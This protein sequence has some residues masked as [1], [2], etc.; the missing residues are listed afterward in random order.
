MLKQLKQADIDAVIAACVAEQA[1][2]AAGA[3]AGP[4]PGQHRL[5]ELIE[6]FSME[7]QD[8]LLALMWTGGPKNQ[9]SFEENLEL[10]Q[11]TVE[12]NHAFH[13][14]EQCAHLPTYLAEGLKKVGPQ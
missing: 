8:E 9:S 11:K 10:V 1:A 12:D 7:A 4:S 3:D 14:A 5:Y 6:S 2:P 13:L